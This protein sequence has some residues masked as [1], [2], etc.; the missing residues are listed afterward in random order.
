MRKSLAVKLFSILML[1]YIA[2]IMSFGFF[3]LNKYSKDLADARRDVVSAYG[4][5]LVNLI[6]RPFSTGNYMIVQD[7]IDVEKAPKFLVSIVVENSNNVSIGESRKPNLACTAQE[8]YTAPLSINDPRLAKNM[9]QGKVKITYTNCDISKK[10]NKSMLAFVFVSIISFVI[11]GIA[12]RVYL[13]FAFLPMERAIVAAHGDEEMDIFIQEKA[14]IEIRPLLKIISRQKTDIANSKVDEAKMELSKQV[15]HDIRSPLTALD[16]ATKNIATIPEDQRVIIRGAIHRIHDI[17]NYLLVSKSKNKEK[18]ETLQL[19]SELVDSILTE[20]RMQYRSKINI[21]IEPEISEQA[22]GQ[23]ININSAQLKIVLS[24]LIDNAVESS[25]QKRLSKVSVIVNSDER[26]ILID[27]VDNGSGINSNLLTD[28]ENGKYRSEGKEGGNGLGLAHAY[29]IIEKNSGY[30]KIQSEM[31]TGTT[32]RISLPIGTPPKWFVP[33]IV[34]V[35]KMTIVILDDD[36]SIHDVWNKRLSQ[37]K[38]L[39]KVVNITTPED[40]RLYFSNND[41]L[42]FFL[43][44]SD[45]E[46]LGHNTTGLDL[47]CE[48]N[49]QKK[50][51]LVTSYYEDPTILGICVKNNIRMIPKNFAIKIPIL[52]QSD[53]SAKKQN[54][55]VIHL[56]DDNILRKSWEISA[57]EHGIEIFSFSDTVNL[58]NSIEDFSKNMTFYLDEDLQE[59]MKGHQVAK[60]LFDHGFEN[61]Y[62]STGYSKEEFKNYSFLKGVIGKEPPWE[63]C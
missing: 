1:I 39:V 53:D 54:N 25:D 60:I 50:S 19:V 41:S 63:N 33:Q 57:K 2:S 4:N 29:K 37:F 16:M 46:L 8:T 36:K 38:E 58:L 61:I 55:A 17:A 27:V 31:N 47:I 3:Y 22:Y 7:Y 42:G 11:S 59:N 28:L 6:K 44:L 62:L 23:F 48:F 52:T 5:S 34:I 12:F 35:P 15:A 10:I 9:D 30:I 56:E 14:H 13:K 20:K 49:L 21:I 40:F 18:L 26:F 32:I 43:L 51:I 45:Y 24:N